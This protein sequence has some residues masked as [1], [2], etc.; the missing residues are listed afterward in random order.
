MT[1]W[2]RSALDLAVDLTAALVLEVGA[3]V[4][5]WRDQ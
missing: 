5:E 4:D 2:I 3:L 1:R